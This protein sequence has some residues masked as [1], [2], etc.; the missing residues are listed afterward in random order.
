MAKYVNKISKEFIIFC[1]LGG[2]TTIINML[3]LALFT[4]IFNINYLISNILAYFISVVISYFL[5]KTIAF[6]KKVSN[7]QRE[8][9]NVILFCLMK[10]ILL[11]ADT[12][13]LYLF[14]SI[15]NISLYISKIILTLVFLIVSYPLTKLIVER[16]GK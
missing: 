2:F 16:K 5:N 1:I 8:L 12:L 14:V 3:L 9:K 7:K 4:E 11:G 15:F 10:G 13:C 6:K